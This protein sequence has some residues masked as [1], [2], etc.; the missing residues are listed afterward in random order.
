MELIDFLL[1]NGSV[2]FVAV[3]CEKFKKDIEPY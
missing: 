2:E 1:L 3:I